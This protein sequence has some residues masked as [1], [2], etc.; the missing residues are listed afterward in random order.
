MNNKPNTGLENWFCLLRLLA[1]SYEILLIALRSVIYA[2][3]FVACKPFCAPC[4][5]SRLF[6]FF[7]RCAD[8]RFFLLAWNHEHKKKK[9]R[10]ETDYVAFSLKPIF[11]RLRQLHDFLFLFIWTFDGSS[12]GF[13]Y[14]DRTTQSSD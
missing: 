9:K 4:V 12:N 5:A 2:H 3:C 1:R 11:F 8:W 13:I 14:I 10:V 7:F 6:F